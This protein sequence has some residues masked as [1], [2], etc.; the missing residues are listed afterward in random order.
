MIF[1]NFKPVLKITLNLYSVKAS[2]GD[3]RKTLASLS[4]MTFQSLMYLHSLIFWWKGTNMK[5]AFHFKLF[6]TVW[7]QK[8][9][10]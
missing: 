5:L 8:Y 3:S 9:A 10:M 4:L 1:W 6:S 7:E 2:Y